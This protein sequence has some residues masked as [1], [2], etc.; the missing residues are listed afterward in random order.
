MTFLIF[1]EKSRTAVP[2]TIVLVPSLVSLLG[3]L[4]KMFI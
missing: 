1:L 2:T 4:L 3:E